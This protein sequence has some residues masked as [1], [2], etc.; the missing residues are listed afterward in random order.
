[1]TVLSVLDSCLDWADGVVAAVGADHRDAAT[2]CPDF[3]VDGLVAHLV[4]G[5]AWY[6]AL[7]AGGATDPREVTG[8]DLAS[9]YVEAFRAARAV[10]RR[11]WTPPRL[12]DTFALPVGEVTG[13]G[14]TEYTVV[15]VLGHGWDL[16]VATGRPVR[17]AD[18]LAEAALRMAR[19]L[20]EDTLRSPGMMGAP[21]PVDAAAPAIDRFVAYLGRRPGSVP[22]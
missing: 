21:T 20:G 2:P 1:M 18:D 15:E 19:G 12:D 5:L 11:N 14:I 22:G 9:G 13:V 3:T 4:D 8:P 16:A 17:V 6:G 10:V 7:P